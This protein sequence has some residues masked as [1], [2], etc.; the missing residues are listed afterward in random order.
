MNMDD[1][2]RFFCEMVI[3]EVKDFDAQPDEGAPEFYWY[4]AGGA[5]VLRLA[6]KRAAEQTEEREKMVEATFYG[7]DGRTKETI[8]AHVKPRNETDGRPEPSGKYL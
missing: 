6:E 7:N 1:L 2:R 3:Q 5:E 8:R 4:I